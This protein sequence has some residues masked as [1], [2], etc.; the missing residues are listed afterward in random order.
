MPMDLKPVIGLEVHAQLKTKSKMFCRCLNDSSESV[1]NANVCP[2]C[3]GHP[4]TLPIINQ[5]ALE[6]TVKAGLALNCQILLSTKFDR[7]NYFYPDLPKGYQISQY[8]LPLCENG[9]LNLKNGRCIS[10]QRIH[11]EEDAGRLV[12]D[13]QNNSLVDFNRAG[14]PLMEL[15]TNPDFQNGEEVREFARELQLIL[16]YLGI[17]EA[18]MEKG[19]MR[20]EANISVQPTEAEFASGTKVEIKNLNSFKAAKA[21]I[22]YEIKRQTEKIKNGEQILQETRGWDGLKTVPQRIK[23]G[24]ADYRYLPEPDLPPVKWQKSFINQIESQLEELP[25]QRRQRFISQYDLSA[26]QSE[27]LTREITLGNYFEKVSSELEN[28]LKI[29]KI[30]KPQNVS[31]NELLANYLISNL[32]GLLKGR[33]TQDKD[34]LITPENFGEFI[35]LVIEKKISSMVAKNIL[36]EMFETGKDPSNIIK[37]RGL[38]QCYEKKQIE[39]EIKELIKENKRAVEDYQKGKESAIQFLLGQLMQRTQGG[40]DPEVGKRTIEQFLKNNTI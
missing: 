35:A 7:K 20:I 26:E 34:L 3:L 9:H 16:R 37:E 38:P 33:L 4:G 1:P 19:E 32:L 28:W 8:D 39:E 5:E 31:P 12:H 14:I 10:I 29:K 25:L 11:L 23:E 2:V 21:A 18:D 6:K 27:I 17:S 36:K 40:I 15:V 30:N 22:E 13:K 24:S